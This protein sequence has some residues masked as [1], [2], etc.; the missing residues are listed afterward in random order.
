VLPRAQRV[1]LWLA[2]VGL[3]VAAGWV[4]YLTAFDSGQPGNYY[5]FRHSREGFTYPTATVMIWLGA[6]AAELAITIAILWLARRSTAAARLF[7]AFLVTL[8]IFLVSLVPFGLTMMH[9]PPYWGA[10]LGLTILAGP[11]TLVL[12]IV[13][14]AV[15]RFSAR[16]TRRN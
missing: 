10:H 5:Q 1:I 6:I 14:A 13:S 12:A 7:L 2:T 3:V 8:T 11:W 4:G 9:A 15:S 16:A